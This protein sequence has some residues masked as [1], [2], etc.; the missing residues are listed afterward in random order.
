MTT[1]DVEGTVR[2]AILEAVAEVGK[3]APDASD[4]TQTFEELGIDSLDFVRL[5]QIIEE[6]LDITLSDEQAAP[7][8]RVDELVVLCEAVLAERH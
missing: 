7:L 5:I 2:A 6:K 3:V 1:T 8:K 4:P